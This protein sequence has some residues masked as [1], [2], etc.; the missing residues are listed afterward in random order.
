MQRSKVPPIF[1]CFKLKPKSRMHIF[2]EL[3]WFDIHKKRW[4]NWIGFFFSSFFCKILNQK[5]QKSIFAPRKISWMRNHIKLLL[6]LFDTMWPYHVKCTWKQILLGIIYRIKVAAVVLVVVAGAT[7]V[8]TI[9]VTIGAGDGAGLNTEGRC[10]GLWTLLNVGLEGL[11]KLGKEKDGKSC[12]L[13]TLNWGLACTN[14][15][16]LA[17]NAKSRAAKT[18]ICK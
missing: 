16:L 9:R 15:L 5:D 4:Q 17:I 7:V 2:V 14:K 8:V 11:E 18:Q 1:Y 6:L 3:C 10:C 12:L 13:K